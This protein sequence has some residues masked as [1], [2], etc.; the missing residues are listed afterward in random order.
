VPPSSTSLSDNPDREGRGWPPRE[1]GDGPASESATGLVTP[2]VEEL[3]TAW[4]RGERLPAEIMLDRQPGLWGNAE[5]AIRLIYEEVCLRQAEGH[6]VPASELVRRFPQWR[7]ELEMLLDCDRLLKEGSE[8]AAFP[9][10]GEAFGGFL[11]LAGLG[12]GARGHCFLATQ[13]AL[14]G[15]QVVIKI[16]PDDQGEHLSLARLQH[17]HIVPLYSE[18]AFPE[19]GL[20]ALCMP[21]LGGAT[22]GQIL[23]SLGDVPP[24]GRTG[25]SL[26]DSLDR[27]GEE[28]G[29][30][31]RSGPSPAR[32]F[33]A[34]VS[35]E[36]A[37]CWIGACLADAL[38]YAHDRGLV[39][40]DLKPSNVLLAADGQP[41]LLDFHLA[42]E[43]VRPGASPPDWLG[44]T[45]GYMSPEQESALEAVRRGRA[46]VAGVDA[47]TD[48]FSLG[49]LL[50]EMLGLSLPAGVGVAPTATRR[51][52]SK[53]SPGLEDAIRK[54][55]APDADER[56]PD[57]GSLAEDLRSHMAHQP[58]RWV[59]NRSPGERWRKWRRQ[60]PAALSRLK[61]M[62][63]ALV[64]VTATAAVAWACYIVPRLHEAERALLDSKIFIARRE[65]PTARQ[66]IARGTAL[67]EGLPGDP[68]LSEEF[69]GLLLLV[70][71]SSDADRLH[72]LV[73]R[74]RSLDTAVP[75][76]P[77]AVNA[78][79]R[80]CHSLW[81][82]RR[83]ILDPIGRGNDREAAERLRADL[84]DLAVVWAELRVRVATGR[85]SEI[86]ARREALA[87]LDEAEATFGPSHILYRGRQA[88][89]G[90]LGLSEVAAAAAVGA[91]RVPPRTAW[92]H[93]AVGRSLLASGN[94]EEAEAAFDRAV[95]LRPQDFWPNFHQGGCAFRLG[96]FA[97]AVGAFR[98]C[99]SLAPDRAEGYYNRA[100]AYSA[101]GQTALA[102][103]DFDRALRLDPSLSPPPSARYAPGHRS[104]R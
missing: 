29:P 73:E 104:G 7:A 39:H 42:R 102:S 8:R 63:S 94:L 72:G 59:A 51:S 82:A 27:R 62:I 78:V 95:A 74:L 65:Y 33:L 69:A 41:M 13:P 43:P 5:S 20:R 18:Q 9:A 23:E 48:I 31:A 40:M 68:G 85:G 76:S 22:L 26:L 89:A 34:H 96:R 98:A 4:R 28:L 70:D 66:A 93:C 47:R 71:R 50:G 91:A 99:V 52:G 75:L 12:R 3:A 58:L 45:P 10:V 92:E 30:M 86:E 25:R 97:D 103:L 16:T 35:Y 53:V 17:T 37:V 77:E 36:R 2:L 1:A 46:P 88:N 19:R 60:R 56:Y 67:I 90:A 84:L 6:E 21:Y 55:L 79:A 57:A 44:G 64:A 81:E 11:L 24:D 32:N 38:Q 100:L 15:R 61:L 101:L 83:P 87:I 54:C 49:A 80:H 14:A